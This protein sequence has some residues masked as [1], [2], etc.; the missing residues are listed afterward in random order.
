MGA[1]RR[2]TGRA[3]A[4]PRRLN[5]PLRHI[6]EM[7]SAFPGFKA[8]VGK[9][10]TVTWI[11]EL[12]PNPSSESYRLRVSYGL[13]GPPRVCVLSPPLEDHAPHRYPSDGSLCLY[14]PREW[15]WRDHESVS[16]TIVGWAALWLE[17]YEIWQVTGE[18]LGPTS[19]AEPREDE[20][21]D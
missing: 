7:R 9:D 1:A 2:R 19:H 18:W 11:G 8:S 12:Q 20:S 17:H 6:P 4:T 21:D 13:Q 16:F 15:R 5:N 14:W 10:R 3:K